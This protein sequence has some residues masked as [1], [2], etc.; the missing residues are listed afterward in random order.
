[1]NEIFYKNKTSERVQRICGFAESKKSAIS[2]PLKYQKVKQLCAL[3]D[4]NGQNSA[5]S[6]IKRAQ[7]TDFFLFLNT[8]QTHNHVACS[9]SLRLENI[10]KSVHKISL[11]ALSTLST[12]SSKNPEIMHPAA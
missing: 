2:F 5:C 6:G 1:M 8:A 4:R 3:T 7:V 9:R 12:T 10:Y 11:T